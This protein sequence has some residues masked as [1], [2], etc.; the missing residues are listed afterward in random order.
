MVEQTGISKN[1][2]E[3]KEKKKN[4]IKNPKL[5]YCVNRDVDPQ[6]YKMNIY[7]LFTI[8]LLLLFTTTATTKTNKQ[9]TTTTKKKQHNPNASTN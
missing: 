9:R 7:L 4:K 3:A 2:N 6:I 1:D 5:F 8:Y